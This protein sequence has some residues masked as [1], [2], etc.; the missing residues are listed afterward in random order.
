MRVAHFVCI[1]AGLTASWASVSAAAD[2]PRNVVLVLID[3]LSHYGVTAYGATKL[4]C[5]G[6][7]FE[8]VTI[9]TPHMDRLAE[10]GMRCAHAFAYPLCEP[11]RVALMS[12][13]WNH[14]NFLKPKSQHASDITFGDVFKKAGYSTGMTGKW[15]QTRGTKEIP[16]QEYISQFGWDEYCCFDV[17]IAGRRYINPNLVINGKPVNYSAKSGMDPATSRRWYGP[18]VCHR[19]ALEFIERHKDQPFFLYYPMV[20]VH[21]EHKP[22]PDTLPA[23]VF[24]EFDDAIDNKNGHHGDDRKYFPNMLAYADKQVGD[25]VAKLDALGL[26]QDTLVVVM[27]DNGT[28]EC[29][30]HHLPDGTSY[31]GGKGGTTDTGTHV[32]LI[33]S[34]PGI[35][36]PSVYD[37]L[38]DLADLYPTLCEAV[39]IVPPNLNEI[40]GISFWPQMLGKTSAEHRQASYVWYNGNN[41][42]NDLSELQEY[43]FDKQ[44]KRYAPSAVFPRGRFFDLRADL[45]ETGGATKVKAPGW[46]KWHYSGLDLDN[47]TAEQQAAFDRLGKVLEANRPVP[48]KAIHIS[49]DPLNLVPGEVSSL[50]AEITPRNAT[51]NNIIWESSDPAVASVDKLGA[52]TAHRAGAATLSAYAW[53]D[54]M[55]LADGQSESFSRRGLSAHVKVTVRT[56]GAATPKGP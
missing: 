36:Q 16:A 20:L 4:S 26:R 15:K 34:L 22:T 38:V 14:R 24:D 43:A 12:G 49:G 10:Q 8:N 17:V 32:P 47:L 45:F 41:S 31:P 1:L 28:K 54:A 7:E 35:I 37:G 6:G 56:A 46:N 33:L 44:F 25:L 50:R 39:G 19:F 42:C 29:F 55:P 27:G 11:T 48:V 40:D 30:T 3:D 13:K 5:T 21:A 53:H 51:R 18:D 23:T 52:V 9:S 2:T